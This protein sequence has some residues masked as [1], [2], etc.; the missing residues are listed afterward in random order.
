MT[1]TGAQAY[2]TDTGTETDGIDIEVAGAL[3]PSWNVYGGYTYLHFRR[4]DANGRTNP[5]H[6]F[7][8][9]STYHVPAPLERLTVGAGVNA[10]TN[11]RAL[12]S[13]AGA[14]SNGASSGPTNVNRSGYAIWNAM[15]KYEITNQT[16]VSLNVNNLFDKTYYTR[17]GFYAGSI[18][19][20]LRNISLTLRTR[21]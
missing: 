8:L 12:S 19:G 6:L 21:F 4:L 3:T 17:Y 10:Q 18:Y 13:P 16:A 15:A 5:S 14:P 20:D 7:K 11:I 2:V 1:S 9:S